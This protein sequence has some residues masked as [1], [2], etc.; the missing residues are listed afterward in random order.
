MKTVMT[1]AEWKKYCTEFRQFGYDPYDSETGREWAS[2]LNN[3]G[4][5]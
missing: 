5:W 3:T 4:G 1:L 2:Y